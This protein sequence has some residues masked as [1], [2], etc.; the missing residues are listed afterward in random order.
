VLNAQG[1]FSPLKH[2]VDVAPMTTTVIEFAAEEFGD[3]F[4]H[5]HLL[6]HMMS[7][8]ARV[9]HY[10]EFAPDPATAAVRPQ[11]YHDPF[12]LVTPAMAGGSDRLKSIGDENCPFNI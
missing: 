7:G 12:Y 1:E 3:W 10:Q 9:V 2:T 6:Y 5:C 8:M 11:L 4:F